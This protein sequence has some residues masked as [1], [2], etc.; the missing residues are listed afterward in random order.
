MTAKLLIKLAG[1]LSLAAQKP[2]PDT[3]E[4]GA[5]KEFRTPPKRIANAAS[6]NWSP[7]SSSS[8]GNSH[9]GVSLLDMDNDEFD[10]MLAG[11][12]G[13]RDS[14]NSKNFRNGEPVL[15]AQVQTPAV[16]LRVPGETP[17][18]GMYHHHT[19]M[20]R[21]G[22]SKKVVNSPPGMPEQW[23]PEWKD[24]FWKEYINRLRI[25]QAEEGFYVLRRNF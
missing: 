6:V 18:V 16:K 25:F 20:V 5:V 23:I 17:E 12:R 2:V 11:E 19:A 24:P 7:A 9:G 13:R 4:N 14:D 21:G 3:K 8:S 10:L 15:Q 1:K 22:H